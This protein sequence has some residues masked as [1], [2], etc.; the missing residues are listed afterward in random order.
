MSSGGFYSAGVILS[1]L[2]SIG[3]PDDEFLTVDEVASLLKV[4]PQ[5]VRNTIDRGDLAA[6]RFGRRVRVRRV[7]LDTFI[8]AETKPS[9]TRVTFEDASRDVAVL[10][11]RGSA[12]QAPVA[13]R[14]LSVAALALASEL[15]PPTD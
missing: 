15:S 14:E 3:M 11:R 9:E 1:Q 13:L 4:N 6:V 2:D 12:E 8:G 10:L 5:T 7:D